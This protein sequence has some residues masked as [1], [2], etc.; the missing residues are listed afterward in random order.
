MDSEVLERD[1]RLCI[2]QSQVSTCLLRE[3]FKAASFAVWDEHIRPDL[4]FGKGLQFCKPCL[5]F[6]NPKDSQ[7]NHPKEHV[8]LVQTYCIDNCI[9]SNVTFDEILWKESQLMDKVFNK[10][11]HLPSFN[12]IHKRNIQEEHGGYIPHELKWYKERV[13]TIEK[14]LDQ[15]KKE[16]S[17]LQQEN[18]ILKEQLDLISEKY[19]KWKTIRDDERMKI[20]M[21]ISNLSQ[22]YSN[23]RDSVI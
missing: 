13:L 4:I 10:V 21:I 9:T 11:C 19:F 12:P 16:K 6:F 1:H 20:E 14:E 18:M 2:E 3:E 23:S 22:I 5:S 8:F 7:S 17:N 15:V